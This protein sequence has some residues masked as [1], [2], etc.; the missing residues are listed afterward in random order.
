MRKIVGF[1]QNVEEGAG[2]GTTT[3]DEA[4][5]TDDSNTV[6]DG[7]SSDLPAQGRT[8]RRRLSKELTAVVDGIVAELSSDSDSTNSDP[9][10]PSSNRTAP[11]IRLPSLPAENNALAL[12]S[13]KLMLGQLILSDDVEEG[14]IHKF[15]SNAK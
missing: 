4:S 10:Q 8:R 5:G 3:A 14:D 2:D 6:I 12:I 7:E 1:L 11:R 13:K 9:V 15:K